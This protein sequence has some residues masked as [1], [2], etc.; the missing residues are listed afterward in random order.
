[1]NP[2]LVPDRKYCSGTRLRSRKEG[3]PWPGR[4]FQENRSSTGIQQLEFQ[5]AIEPGSSSGSEGQRLESSWLIPVW[6]SVRW[7]GTRKLCWSTHA[8]DRDD[9]I[10]NQVGLLTESRNNYAS[11]WETGWK[12]SSSRI[13]WKKR[14]NLLQ[15]TWIAGIIV[16]GTLVKNGIM[17]KQMCKAFGEKCS[18]IQNKSGNTWPRITGM[19]P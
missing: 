8:E 3:E 16:Y 11:N 14:K 10:I 13:E 7:P 6:V 19:N 15:D 18:M 12:A 2:C 5:I 9:D 4:V 17:E 1:M